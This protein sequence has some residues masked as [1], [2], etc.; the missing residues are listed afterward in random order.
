MLKSK[1][2]QDLKAAL[3]AGDKAKA[4]VLRLIKSAI[5]YEEVAKKVRDTGLPDED[6]LVVLA[7]ESK[8]RTESAEMYD[9]G[10]RPERAAAER[11]EKEIIDSYL[12]EQL[13]NEELQKIVADV[14]SVNQDAQMGQVIGLVRAKVGQSADGGRIAATVKA[15]LQK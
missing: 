15:A 6:I 13:S 9:K 8:K 5:L 11:A 2:D 4:E 12:P 14:I 7:R 10:D 3:L 1:I